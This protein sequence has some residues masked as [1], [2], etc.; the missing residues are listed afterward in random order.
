MSHSK[1]EFEKLQD[2]YDEIPT[3]DCKG[4]CHESCGPIT[5]TQI[6][7]E[8]ITSKGQ[9]PPEPQSGTMT[10]SKL[11]P[12]VKKCSIYEDRPLICR[13]FGVVEGMKCEHGCTPEGGY[14]S[15]QRAFQLMRKAEKLSSK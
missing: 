13:L 9:D 12:L 7:E 10:C 2:I 8:R 15:D 4:K 5:Y 1:D 14:M 6:E 3:L 11:I